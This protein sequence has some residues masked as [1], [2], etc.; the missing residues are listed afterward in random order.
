MRGE[1][2]REHKIRKRNINTK[3]KHKQRH[4]RRGE[5]AIMACMIL[6]TCAATEEL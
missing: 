5:T 4:D 3:K 2:K 1:K 6:L